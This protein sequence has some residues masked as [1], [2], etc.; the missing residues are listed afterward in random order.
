MN[1]GRPKT[2]KVSSMTAPGYC[3]E[4]CPGTGR[5]KQEVVGFWRWGDRVEKLG[6]PRHLVLTRQNNTKDKAGK[7]TPAICGVSALGI[8]QR[9]DQF[10]CLRKLPEMREKLSKRKNENSA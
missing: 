1:H 4:H 10:T 5:R 2:V 3:L 9:I 7:K 6:R 8:H